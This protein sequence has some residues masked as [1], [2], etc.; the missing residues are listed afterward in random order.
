MR[1]LQKGWVRVLVALLGGSIISELLHISTGNPNRPRAEGFLL[2]Y[3]ILV[4]IVLT[5]IAKQQNK[6]MK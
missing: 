4:Y 2:L 6:G 1:H 3:A 5:G